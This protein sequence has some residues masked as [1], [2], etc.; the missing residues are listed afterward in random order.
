MMFATP[1]LMGDYSD[2][3]VVRINVTGDDFQIY[4]PLIFME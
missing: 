4:L 3:A 2:S 1:G